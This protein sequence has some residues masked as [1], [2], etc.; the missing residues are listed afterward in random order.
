MVLY[1]LI[2]KYSILGMLHDEEGI[3]AWRNYHMMMDIMKHRTPIYSLLCVCIVK[4]FT[5]I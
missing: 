3:D 4:M 1:F 2:S 5:L